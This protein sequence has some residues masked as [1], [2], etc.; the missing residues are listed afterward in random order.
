M[1]FNG[2]FEVNDKKYITLTPKGRYL[3]VAM[4]REFFSQ[5]D[6]IRDQGRRTLSEEEKDLFLGLDTA[7][8]ISPGPT[9]C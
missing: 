6:H 2:A 7:P 8:V 1:Q 3:L 5:V 9:W 4:M